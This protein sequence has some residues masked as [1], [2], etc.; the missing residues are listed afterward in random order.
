MS[1][2]NRAHHVVTQRAGVQL[3]VHVDGS[4]DVPPI[5]GALGTAAAAESQ[6][7]ILNNVVESAFVR[8]DDRSTPERRRARGVAAHGILSLMS[9]INANRR[10]IENWA[11]HTARPTNARTGRQVL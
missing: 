5:L 6:D 7:S 11:A 1:P 8:L 4:E 2:D 3:T 9:I 10:A